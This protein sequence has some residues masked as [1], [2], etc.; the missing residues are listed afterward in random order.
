M[1]FGILTRR[2]MPDIRSSRLQRAPHV[3]A[4]VQGEEIVLLDTSRERYYTLNAIAAR[5]WELLEGSTTFAG[6]VTAIRAEYDAPAGAEGD[7]VDED[8]RQLLTQLR[9]AGLLV[10]RSTEGMQ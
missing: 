3:L 10:V 1:R 6:M 7:R 5:V 8:M 2:P 4:T 9:T